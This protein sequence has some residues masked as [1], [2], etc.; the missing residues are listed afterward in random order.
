MYYRITTVKEKGQSLE[1]M[2]IFLDTHRTKLKVLNAV[3][4]NVIDIGNNTAVMV[5]LYKSKK[6]A[7]EAT[8]KAKEILSESQK[9]IKEPPIQ[10]EGEVV[11]AL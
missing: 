4:I 1:E 7:D 9:M 8:I 2:K 5:T 6:D 11:W 10:V 3:S